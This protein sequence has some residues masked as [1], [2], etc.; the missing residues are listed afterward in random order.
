MTKNRK[1]YLRSIAAALVLV[2]GLMMPTTMSPVEASCPQVLPNG[3][4]YEKLSADWWKWAY[5]FPTQINPLFDETGT[6]GYLGNQRNVFF[7]AGVINV[8]GTAERTITVPAGK[9]LFFPI[10]NVEWDNILARPP[11]L[12]GP[13]TPP[14][15]FN[16][17]SVP[18]LYQ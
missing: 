13:F 7:L 3:Q 4:A 15:Q 12:G 16:P 9:P 14:P 11:Y 2:L 1:Q 10:L 8:S 6:Q 5:S 18:E 17:L